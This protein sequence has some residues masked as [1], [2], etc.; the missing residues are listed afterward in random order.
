MQKM[1]SFSTNPA[2]AVPVPVQPVL[3]GMLI[4][5]PS[6]SDSALPDVADRFRKDA[7]G[8]KF[9]RPA[10]DAP[11]RSRHQECSVNTCGS[12]IRFSGDAN[13]S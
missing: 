11:N 2:E 5:L 3:Y 6:R 7:P 12:S 13:Q 9:C 4:M 8:Q 10:L 1:D